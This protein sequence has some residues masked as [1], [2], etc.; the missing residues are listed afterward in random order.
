VSK[1]LKSAVARIH[2]DGIVV[3]GDMN[4]VSGRAALDTILKSVTARPLSPMMRVDALHLDGWTDW[5][6]DGT[7]TPFNGGRLDN[8]VYSAGTLTP[9]FSR[10]WDT[11]D[12]PPDTLRA[13]GLEATSSKDINRHRPVVVDFVFRSAP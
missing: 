5:T 2:P 3:A 1:R 13:H 7:G 4:L 12:M 11:A 10:I 6:W 8:F 9:Q